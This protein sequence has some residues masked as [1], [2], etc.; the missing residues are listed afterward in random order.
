[1]IFPEFSQQM[2][3]FKTKSAQYLLKH[4]PAPED[5]LACGLGPLTDVLRKVS[6]GK[7]GAERARGLYEA[8]QDSVGIREGRESILFEIQEILSN[9]EASDRFV[10]R[11]EKEL[12]KHLQEIPASRYLLSMNGIGEITAA[13][14]IGEVADFDNFHTISEVTKLAGLDLF[15][16]SSGKHRGMRRISKRGRPLMRKLLYFAALNTVRKGG[17]MHE[18]YRAYLDRGMV[19]TKALVA[20]G[21]KILGILFALVRDH[22][23]Y[24]KGY[25]NTANLDK[26]A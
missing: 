23:E 13:G 2:K 25:S 9:I 24:V 20:I 19:K 7:L 3:D 12:S 26:A 8:A 10:S 17:V 1:M 11:L 4:F 6:R 22:S 15:E 14:L 16:I 18:K 5:I 21:R